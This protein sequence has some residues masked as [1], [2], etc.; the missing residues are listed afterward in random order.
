MEID[1]EKASFK[2]FENIEGC[3]RYARASIFNDYLNFSDRS[4]HLNYRMESASGCAPERNVLIPGKCKPEKLASALSDDY[5]AFTKHQKIKEAVMRAAGP[6]ATGFKQGLP[7]MDAGITRPAIIPVKIADLQKT[8]KAVRLLFEQGVYTHPI[9]YPGVSKRNARISMRLTGTR[10]KQ[11]PDKTLNAF[12]Y[13][14]NKIGS[15]KRNVASD[16]NRI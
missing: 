5:P 13:V 14:D 6:H 4:W 9:I 7:G 15:K 10:C 11:Q 2:D 1:F 3:H 8:G 16:E 12:E